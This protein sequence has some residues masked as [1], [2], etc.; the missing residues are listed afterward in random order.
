M[1]QN[2]NTDT[3]L[4]LWQTVLVNTV[5]DDRPDLSMRQMALLLTVYTTPPPHTVRGLAKTLNISKPAIT[6]ALDRLCGI[7]LARRKRDDTDRRNVLIQRT[8]KG[9]VVDGVD[10][11]ARPRR[12]TT[13]GTGALGAR[14]SYIWAPFGA[15]HALP[16][17][18]KSVGTHDKG[19]PMSDCARMS[20]Y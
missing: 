18:T 2:L 13:T 11:F 7:D 3:A 14:S 5:R 9:S 17:L 19:A 8:V 1:A 10:D 20:Y 15:R 4:H 12:F 6:R 16:D